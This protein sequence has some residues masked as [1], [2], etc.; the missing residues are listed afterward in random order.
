MIDN[1]ILLFSQIEIWIFI[2]MSMALLPILMYLRRFYPDSVREKMQ[3]E[4]ACTLAV[5]QKPEMKR[6]RKIVFIGFVLSVVI[7]YILAYYL[8]P[9]IQ[10]Q[11][12]MFVNIFIGSTSLVAGYSMLSEYKINKDKNCNDKIVGYKFMKWFGIFSLVAYCILI[13]IFV[14]NEFK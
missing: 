3:R 2:L 6:L 10:T 8:L 4:E 11:F 14:W 12:K 5:N 7:S 13:I 1:F 9:V